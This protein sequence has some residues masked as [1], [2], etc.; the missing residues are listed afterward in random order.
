MTLEAFDWNCQQH[1]EP[2]FTAEDINAVVAPMQHEI[3]QLRA[4]NERL[5]GQVG[6]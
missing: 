2:R 6:G 3:A 5:K 1:I 4:E